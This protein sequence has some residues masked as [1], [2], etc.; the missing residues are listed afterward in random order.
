MLKL[1]G[2]SVYL[3]TLENMALWRN[4]L[5]IHDFE[6]DIVKQHIGKPDRFQCLED[7][8]RMLKQK[9]EGEYQ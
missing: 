4:G 8:R 3:A 9:T 2:E 5:L 1:Q 6:G 7:L